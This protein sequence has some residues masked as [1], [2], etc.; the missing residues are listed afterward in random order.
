MCSRPSAG[1]QV[2]KEELLEAAA[3]AA[4]CQVGLGADGPLRARS[5]RRG[6]TC[7]DDPVRQSASPPVRQSACPPAQV[8][9][10]SER[11]ATIRALGLATDHLTLVRD[12]DT[13]RAYPWLDSPPSP[14]TAPNGL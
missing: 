3:E 1:S 8:W 9:V 13:R 7:G 10:S 6:P 5:R 14:A 2:G 4:G 11:Y 12:T